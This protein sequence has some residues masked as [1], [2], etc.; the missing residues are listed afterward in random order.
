[1]PL[2][3][4][5]RQDFYKA[6]IRALLSVDHQATHVQLLEKLKAE[7]ITLDREYLSKLVGKVL[8]ERIKRADRQTLNYALAAFEDTI[9]TD[10]KRVFHY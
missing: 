7:G 10:E 8:R 6:R 2:V 9:V 4:K 3:A 1:M 5:D